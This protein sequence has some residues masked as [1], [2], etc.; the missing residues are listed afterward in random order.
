MDFG[1]IDFSDKGEGFY[2]KFNTEIISLCDTLPESIQTD[3]LLFFMKNSGLSIGQELHFFKNYY[4]PSWSI[5]FWLTQYLPDNNES[6]QD[7]TQNAISAHAMAMMLHSM[8]DHINDGQLPASH[9]ALLLRS[10]A[11]MRM[12]HSLK[13]LSSGFHSGKKIITDFLDSYYTSVLGSDDTNTLD[14]YCERFRKQMA[15]W[16]IVPVLLTKA[17]KK[18]DEFSRGVQAAFESFGIAWRLLDDINDIRTDMKNGTHSAIYV[19]LPDEIRTLWDRD[20]RTDINNKNTRQDIILNHIMDARLI[21]K[22]RKNICRELQ[23][24][25]SISE[26]IHL[27]GLAN[28]FRYL[29]K[30]LK[31]K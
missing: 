12:N 19:C 2:K 6:F 24:A 29:L 27:R 22:L 20:E 4:V 23:S 11:W 15:T 13:S 1:S 25:V 31:D 17:I 21:R 10:Q 16:L 26:N 14:N 9:L 28:E 30:P 8:D 3:A 18:D 5:V 7:I